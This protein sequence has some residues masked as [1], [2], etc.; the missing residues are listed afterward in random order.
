M[1]IPICGAGVSLFLRYLPPYDFGSGRM[2][3]PQRGPTVAARIRSRLAQRDSEG[4]YVWAWRGSDSCITC[5]WYTRHVSI[6]L[7]R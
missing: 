3:E 7:C 6:Q 5:K 4:R 1:M 2:T